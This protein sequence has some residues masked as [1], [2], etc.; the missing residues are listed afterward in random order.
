MKQS[1][2]VEMITLKLLSDIYSLCSP[3]RAIPFRDWV[4]TLGADRDQLLI[5]KFEKTILHKKQ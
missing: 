5:Q 3:Q 1:K 4:W 2:V